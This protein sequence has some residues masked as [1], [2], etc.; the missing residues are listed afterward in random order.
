MKTGKLITVQTDKETG[1]G[2][3]LLE[4]LKEF[5]DITKVDK[6]EFSEMLDENKKTVGLTLKFFDK[7]GN[8]IKD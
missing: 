4:D 7:D 8:Q 1:D 2:F 5:V 6:Y 3:I